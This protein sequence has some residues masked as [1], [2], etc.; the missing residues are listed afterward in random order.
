MWVTNAFRGSSCGKGQSVC[1][2]RASWSTAL[3]FM[4]FSASVASSGHVV[5]SVFLV[6]VLVFLACCSAHGRPRHER[7]T[8]PWVCH[9]SAC[10]RLFGRP[11]H[12]SSWGRASWPSQRY[13]RK[14]SGAGAVGSE[15]EWGEERGKGRRRRRKKSR[16]RSRRKRSECRLRPQHGPNAFDRTTDLPTFSAEI[17]QY[18]PVSAY[19]GKTWHMLTNACSAGAKCSLVLADFGRVGS[20]VATVWPSLARC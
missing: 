13:D 2:K 10:W 5:R 18:G 16:R 4:P 19:L 11:S 14:E 12:A 6:L 1:L 15:A 20:I 17:G 3:Q 9:C 7:R 8:W